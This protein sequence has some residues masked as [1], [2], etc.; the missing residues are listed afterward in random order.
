MQITNIRYIQSDNGLPL[1]KLDLDGVEATLDPQQKFLDRDVVVLTLPPGQADHLPPVLLP[2]D[3]ARSIGP[4][5]LRGATRDKEVLRL[6]R[7]FV[8]AV[9]SGRFRVGPV[10]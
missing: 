1:L 8:G 7:A 6:A 4:L 2:A 3:P 10:G 5:T 9:E